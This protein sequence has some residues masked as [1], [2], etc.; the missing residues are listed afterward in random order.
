MVQGG[1][2]PQ[3]LRTV[4][5]K[6]VT[7]TGVVEGKRGT[8]QVVAGRCSRQAVVQVQ[9]EGSVCRGRQVAGESRTPM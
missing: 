1:G 2:S 6:Y 4:N 5:E 7:V 9:V 8:S 3:A